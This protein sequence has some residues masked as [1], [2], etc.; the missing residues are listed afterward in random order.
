M[1]ASRSFSFSLSFWGAAGQVLSRSSSCMVK[2]RCWGLLRWS[3]PAPDS[4]SSM[5]IWAALSPIR[6][7]GISMEVMVVWSMAPISWPVRLMILIWSGI[8]SPRW[9]TARMAPSPWTST[10]ARMASR[11]GVSSSSWLA[12]S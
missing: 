3:G 11:S 12:Q 7:A 8:L 2:L 5:I 1:F 4:I 10:A 6:W 9:V